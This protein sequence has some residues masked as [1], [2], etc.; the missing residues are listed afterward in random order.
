MIV[1]D[2]ASADGSADLVQKKFPKV[3]LIHN[4]ENRYFTGANNQKLSEAKG[5]HLLILNVYGKKKFQRVQIIQLKM[6]RG[7]LQ[8]S[9]FSCI[10]TNGFRYE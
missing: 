3:R 4:A 5:K 6:D 9:V 10:A 1:I 8:Q 7:K 2:N